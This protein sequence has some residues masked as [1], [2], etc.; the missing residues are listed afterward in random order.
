MKFKLE[1]ASDLLEALA[2]N[3]PEASKTTLRQML[4]QGRVSVNGETEKDARRAI[5]A[6]DEIVVGRRTSVANLTT[7]LALLF[8]DD[9]IIVIIKSA[10]MLTVGTADEKE[11][12]AQRY[13]NEYLRTKRG[14]RVHVVH[15]L[16]RDTSGV[17]M[18]AKNFETR[19]ILK[20]TF[21]AH[22][23]DRVYVAI[24]E[25]KPPQKEG[26]IR[27][28]LFEDDRMMKVRSVAD[29]KQGKLAVTHYRVL[30]AGGKY[31]KLEVTLETGRKNQIRVHFS[32]QG[33]P[34]AGD[35]RYGAKTDP[36]GR[37][38]LHAQMLGFVHPKTK[39]KMIFT[40][41]LPDVFRKI[42][43]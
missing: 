2:Q 5:S 15:R 14:S 22:D 13:L 3:F 29:P 41:P 11:K 28:Y 42:E 19:E 36:L 7:E 23:I 37:L 20:D 17:M 38:G 6:G 32:E 21:A 31:T 9:D 33:F 4:Q 27:S 35:S 43:L 18:F 12:T 1:A 24:V 30:E 39:K 8:E 25:G 16:D 26:T 40:A 34:V 10:G